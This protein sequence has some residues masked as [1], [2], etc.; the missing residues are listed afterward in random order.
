MVKFFQ[1]TYKS[2]INNQSLSNQTPSLEQMISQ[3]RNE[4]VL[5]HSKSEEVS[6]RG[7][8]QLVSLLQQQSKHLETSNMENTRLQELCK[9]NSIDYAIPVQKPVPVPKVVTSAKKAK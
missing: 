4:I 2:Q 8:D 3:A 5:M 7:F 6:I 9:E 1:N